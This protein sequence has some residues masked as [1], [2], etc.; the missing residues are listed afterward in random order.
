MKNG[1]LEELTLFASCSDI[2]N[3]LATSFRALTSQ[4]QNNH[5]IKHKITQHNTKAEMISRV[6][7][8]S[9]VLFVFTGNIYSRHLNILNIVC[10]HWFKTAFQS[11]FLNSSTISMHSLRWFKLGGDDCSYSRSPRSCQSGRA[12]EWIYTGM[13]DCYLRNCR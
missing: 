5:P 3:T 2:F 7:F 12:F 8:S 13:G 1:T 11:K 6:Q 9:F 10:I 4:K